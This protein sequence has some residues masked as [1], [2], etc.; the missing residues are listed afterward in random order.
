MLHNPGAS[1]GERDGDDGATLFDLSLELRKAGVKRVS[2]H[3]TGDGSSGAVKVRRP[4]TP[5][6]RGRRRPRPALR[7]SGRRCQLEEADLHPGHEPTASRPRESDGRAS[8][9]NQPPTPA[10][11]DGERRPQGN[12]LPDCPE[13]LKRQGNKTPPVSVPCFTHC[14]TCE[15]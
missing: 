9:D 8:E 10:S 11:R 4:T 5:V 14:R 1:A 3:V 12:Q 6:R 7:S 13:T 2:L 15:G